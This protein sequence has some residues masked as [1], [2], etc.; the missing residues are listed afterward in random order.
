MDE[1]K[2]ARKDEKK[3]GED[4][5]MEALKSSLREMEAELVRGGLAFFTTLTCVQ[6]SNDPNVTELKKMLREYESR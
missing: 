3:Q 2:L 5:V 1:L 6:G 4:G